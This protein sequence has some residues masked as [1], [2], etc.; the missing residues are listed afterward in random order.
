MLFLANL[1][2]AALVNLVVNI[3]DFILQNNPQ[4][5]CEPESGV[6]SHISACLGHL[7]SCSTFIITSEVRL[8]E[9]NFMSRIININ[10]DINNSY[11]SY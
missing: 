10:Y 5:A 1:L 8:D 7:F 4:K 3:D 9:H 2:L 6:E 11:W